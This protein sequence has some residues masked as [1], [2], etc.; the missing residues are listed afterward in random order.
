VWPIFSI[1]YDFLLIL[2]S[3]IWSSDPF[4]WPP[5]LSHGQLKLKNSNKL[6]IEVYFGFNVQEKVNI[7]KTFHFVIQERVYE[8]LQDVVSSNDGKIDHETI[9]QMHYLE[10][11]I[12][13]N[14]RICGPVT[15]SVRLCS[16]DCEIGGIKFKKG[17]GILMPTWPSHHNEEFFPEPEVFR[18]E[19]Y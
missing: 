7:E 18:P 10:A 14:L 13:E 4:W 2:E 11:A 8:E 19:R 16:Q 6:Q 9:S 15:D 17:T 5:K 12:N 3:K 1:K